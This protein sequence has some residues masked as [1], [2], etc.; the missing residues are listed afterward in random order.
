MSSVLVVVEH[1]RGALAPATLEGLTAARALGR[2]AIATLEKH[3]TDGHTPT[4]AEPVPA[5]VT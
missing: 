4:A 2:L 3:V 1:D 5:S